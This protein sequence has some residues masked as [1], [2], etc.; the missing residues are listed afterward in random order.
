VANYNF[1]LEKQAL[2][3]R[4]AP[5]LICTNSD[6]RHIAAGYSNYRWRRDQQFAMHRIS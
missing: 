6:G 1:P 3:G 5:E 4:L 2:L